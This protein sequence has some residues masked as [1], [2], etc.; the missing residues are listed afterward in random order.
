MLVIPIRSTVH[1]Y[2]SASPRF[3]S[4]PF[5]QF[6]AGSGNDF[7]FVQK[8]KKKNSHLSRLFDDYKLTSTRVLRKLLNSW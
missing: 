5:L 7:Q 4:W 6:Y 8:K 2:N 1:R 3:P